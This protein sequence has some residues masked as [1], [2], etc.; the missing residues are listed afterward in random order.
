MGKKIGGLMPFK[1]LFVKEKLSTFFLHPK[2]GSLH[3]GTDITKYKWNCHCFQVRLKIKRIQTFKSNVM[4][5]LWSIHHITHISS[6]LIKY[7]IIIGK[8][9]LNEAEIYILHGDMLTSRAAEKCKT[10]CRTSF[11]AI[12]L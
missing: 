7:F 3:P 9:G 1:T 4:F 2:N 12:F 8:T 11:I 10:I 6:N 5:W